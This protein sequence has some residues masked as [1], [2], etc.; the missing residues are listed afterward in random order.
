[1]LEVAAKGT[2]V[3]KI[4]EKLKRWRAKSKQA[5]PCLMHFRQ[6]SGL[7]FW[8]QPAGSVGSWIFDL[9]PAALGCSAPTENLLYK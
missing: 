4:H 2:P 7:A 5:V 6:A 9:G 8:L 3:K 1:M